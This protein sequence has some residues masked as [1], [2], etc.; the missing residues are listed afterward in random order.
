MKESKIYRTVAPCISD[1]KIMSFGFLIAIPSGLLG[2]IGTIMF[3][4]ERFRVY[5]QFTSRVYYW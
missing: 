2:L 3:I 4:I 5:F 1:G